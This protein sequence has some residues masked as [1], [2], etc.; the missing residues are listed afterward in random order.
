MQKTKVVF[1]I[2]H[3]IQYY[4]P[5]LQ[6]LSKN[7]LL[8]IQVFYTW[9][10]ESIAKFDPGFNKTIEWDI[11]LLEGYKYKFLNNIAKDPGSHHYN[12]IDN[13]SIINEIQQSSPDKI[14]VF[15]W[16]YKSH[17]KVLRKFHGKVPI[18]FRGDSHLL[19]E[20][21]GIKKWL[22]R[23]FLR[24]VYKKVDFAISV[25]TQN[26]A[27][28]KAMGMN[29]SQILFAPHAIDESRFLMS[30]DNHLSQAWR[31]TLEI[32]DDHTI[33]I[34]IGKFE[35]RKNLET[36]IKAK[37]KLKH[38]SCTLLLVGSGP[39]EQMLKNLANGDPNIHFHGFVNQANIASMYQLADVFV[40]TS[41]SETWGLGINE[42][43]NCGLAIVA[44]DKV[45]CAVDLVK[46]NGLIFKA[47][48]EIDLADKML[49]LLKDRVL[50]TKM[51]NNSKELISKWSIKNLISNFEQALLSK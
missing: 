50:L 12:G 18:Y 1:I 39:E 34:Y 51:K 3:P 44:S 43:M 21:V 19:N 30:K 36:L 47:E 33:F 9:G 8:D 22:R 37:K 45:G 24:W 31:N 26:E 11:P 17:L 20:G 5:L 40:L 35:Y 38:E 16:S 28:Y 7:E 41:V 29:S 48:N 42:A 10:E 46:D 4:V 25:G 32:P 2:T 27:Y 15:G 14:V 23:I 6:G 49:T 13:P